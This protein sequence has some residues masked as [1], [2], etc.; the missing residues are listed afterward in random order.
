MFSPTDT[1]IQTG[2]TNNY[3]L[4]KQLESIVEMLKHGA[5]GKKL[6]SF[7][8]SANQTQS[9]RTRRQITGAKSPQKVCPNVKLPEPTSRLAVHSCGTAKSPSIL[10]DHSHVDIVSEDTSI[11]SNL[12]VPDIECT[13]SSRRL[14]TLIA[15]TSDGKENSKRLLSKNVTGIGNSETKSCTNVTNSVSTNTSNRLQTPTQSSLNPKCLHFSSSDTDILS[16]RHDT[17]HARSSSATDYLETSDTRTTKLKDKKTCSNSNSNQGSKEGTSESS[18]LSV[19]AWSTLKG[20]EDNNNNGSRE[21]LVSRSDTVKSNHKTVSVDENESTTSDERTSETHLTK[22]PINTDVSNK[23]DSCSPTTS[24]SSSK[25]KRDFGKPD[26]HETTNVNTCDSWLNGAPGIVGGDKL[27]AKFGMQ[28]SSSTDSS[29]HEMS[30]Y[31]FTIRIR[32]EVTKHF[33]PCHDHGRALSVTLVC[34]CVCVCVC[35]CA[36]VRACVRVCVC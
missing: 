25:E 29:D 10:A 32:L 27:L 7:S 18:S 31:C 24:D 33:M 14:Q 6:K 13:E 35:V 4:W 30:M 3:L 12:S 19:Q 26:I 21:E 16:H 8:Q 5:S 28:Q 15:P 34:M 11:V 20:D 23:A 2:H 1:A 36:C 9:A 22:A 17:L